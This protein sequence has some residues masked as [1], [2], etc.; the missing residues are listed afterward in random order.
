M[1]ALV[2]YIK[3]HP[4]WRKELVE[5]PFCLTIKDDDPYTIFSYS[6]IDSDFYNPVVR[7][8]RGIIL[9]IVEFST[10]VDYIGEDKNKA[11]R[12]VEVVCA[13]FFKFANYGE[14]YAD[15]IDWAS[16]RIQE[17]IDGSL[18]KLFFDEDTWHIATNSMIDAFKCNLML[19]TEEY[20][21]FGDLFMA[22]WR[23]SPYRDT[24]FINA[25]KNVEN[26]TL[27]FELTS[28]FNRVVVPYKE[29]KISL[30]GARD[31]RTEQEVDPASLELLFDRP[32]TYNFGSL[33]E[34]LENIKHLPY[35][36]E[37]Y[38]V[39]DKNWGRNK[40][41][42]LNYLAVHHM[43]SNDGAVN[44]SRVL[45]LIKGNEQGEF[46]TYFPEYREHFD[47][48]KAKY[49]ATMALIESVAASVKILKQ[50]NKSRK[51]FAL[52]VLRKNEKMRKYYFAY[53]DGNDDKV[54]K[55]I[56]DL[57]YEDLL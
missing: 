28:P 26:Y 34:I 40:I 20:K 15:K 9:K 2:D 17:K 37:G 50:F 6:Q 36:Q 45:D 24:P 41:K 21:M 51:D 16:A 52:E 33:E 44:P 35:D 25:L 3:T 29:I 23:N 31:L 56:A 18:L 5:K 39:V 46:L 1:N 47:K 43:R 12:E 4:D 22:A 53:Y 13:P 8:S 14:G 11:F 49:D 55:M 7:V 10:L 48:I 30:I 38:V 32:K 42:S 54:K 57:D 19:P 27:C